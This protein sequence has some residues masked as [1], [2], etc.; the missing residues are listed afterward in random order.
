MY[1]ITPPAKAVTD[2]LEAW[3][4]IGIAEKRP[5]LITAFADVFFDSADGVWFLDTLEGKLKRVCETR[6]E[7]ETI[8]A[9]EEGKDLYLLSGFI[10]RAIRES[11]VLKD[12]ECYDFRLHPV[13]GGA[14]DYSNVATISFVVALHLR[15][16]IHDQ[17]RHMKPGT[18]ISKFVL[19]KDGASKPWWKL[20]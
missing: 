16:Q 19:A 18:R 6:D 10:D 2:A 7:L 5:I 20:W 1:F 4:W 12:G 13:V 17:V 14:I 11:R 9:T 3:D 15:G 8:L